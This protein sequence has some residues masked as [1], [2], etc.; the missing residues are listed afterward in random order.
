MYVKEIVTRDL[1]VLYLLSLDDLEVS[2][3]TDRVVSNS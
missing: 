2:T 3:I 1:Y